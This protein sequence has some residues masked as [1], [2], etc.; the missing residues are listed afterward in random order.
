[1]P[2][3]SRNKISP[4]GIKLIITLGLSLLFGL[5]WFILFYG[6]SPL[7]FT[8]VDWIYKAGGDLF[9]TQIGWEW[10]RQTPWHFPLGRIDLYGYP[11]G[12]YVTYMNSIPLPAIFFKLFTAVLPK[13]FQ[14]L[15]LWNLLSIVGQMF[16]G[17]LI[18][19]EFTPSYFKKI[20]GAS[21]LVL[22][23]TLIFRAFYH[24]SLTSQWI[25]L[26]GIWL[27]LMQ[28]R[29]RESRR[30]AWILLFAV[31]LVIHIYLMVMLVPLWAISL[32]FRF[33]REKNT[34]MLLVDIFVM[35]GLM[36]L[37]GY[38]TGL[39]SLRAGDLYLKGFGYYSWNL[40]GFFDPQQTSALFHALPAGT[41]GQ[42]EGLSYLGLGNL[43]TLPFALFLFFKKE[44]SRRHLLFLLPFAVVSLLFTLFALSNEAFVSTHSLW[45]IQLPD[46]IFKVFSLFRASARFIWPVFYFVV[47]FGLIMLVRN[48]RFAT[49]ILLLAVVLQLIDLQ[50]LYASKKVNGV[51]AYRSEL[52]SEFWQTAAQTN[53]H[54]FIYP[55]EDAWTVY[56]PFALYT[57]H[58]NMTLNWGYFSRANYAEIANFGRHTWE[59]LKAD[60]VAKDT[61]FIIWGDD[62]LAQAKQ[63]LSDKML[64]CQIDGY[65]VAF[66]PNNPVVQSGFDLKPYCAFP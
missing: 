32:F 50:P 3:S 12:T 8:S 14:Y 42:Y 36:L 18:L 33:K 37:L 62:A 53:Q 25:I 61:L 48:T 29:H 66:S 56:E 47:L 28:Y 2:V 57:L 27:I 52:Q 23:T 7:N 40:D 43:V 17:M 44:L 19:G 65:E 49:L 55:A 6:P 20:L 60:H 9:Q 59:D 26:A 38:S 39:F 58:N 5:A 10:F 13:H 24:D 30:A 45:N 4:Q 41:A 1:M 15:G 63:F 21:L 31:A 22:S 54:V 11:F 34:R 46:V 64:I 16:F 51:E 35:M